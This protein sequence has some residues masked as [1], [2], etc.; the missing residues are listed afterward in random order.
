MGGKPEVVSTGPW[1][2]MVA[3]TNTVGTTDAQSRD[4]TVSM[5]EKC[6]EG[7]R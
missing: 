7:D 3:V 1:I 5:G 6:K 2:C 4:D